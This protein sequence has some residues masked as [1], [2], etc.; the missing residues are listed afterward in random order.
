MTDGVTVVAG[1]QVLAVGMR[2]PIY[3]NSVER[4][5]AAVVEDEYPLELRHFEDLESIR[6]RPQP[7]ARRG[8]AASVRFELI[9]DAIARTAP[10]PRLERNIAESRS[11]REL[12]QRFCVASSAR[13]RRSLIPAEGKPQAELSRSGAAC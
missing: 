2:P 13:T 12:L 3:I 6:R 1:H 4:M 10:G 9:S 11:I 8:L 5:G 7:R